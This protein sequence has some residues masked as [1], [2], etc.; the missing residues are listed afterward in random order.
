MLLVLIGGLLAGASALLMDR[1]RGYLAEE[2]IGT[3]AAQVRDEVR[4]L[5]RPLEQ[6][7]LIARDALDELNPSDEKGINERLV[8]VLTHIPQISGAIDARTDGTECYLRQDGD[9]WLTR[10]RGPGSAKD[11]RFTRWDAQAEPL[12]QETRQSD[13]DP[14]TRPWLN[15]ALDTPNRVAWTAPYVFQSLGRPRHHRR[16]RLERG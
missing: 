1:L 9:G 15:D 14:R 13:C 16:H 10:L 4:A 11:Q 2:R 12:S 7:L 5:L 8:P 6:Q 3:A